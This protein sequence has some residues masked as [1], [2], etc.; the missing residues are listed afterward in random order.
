MLYDDGEI[1]EVDMLSGHELLMIAYDCYVVKLS[2]HAAW[3]AMEWVCCEALERAG[4]MKMWNGKPDSKMMII[5]FGTEEQAVVPRPDDGS[6]AGSEAGWA[7]PPAKKKGKKRDNRSAPSVAR[8]E[9][10]GANHA[11]I[12]T[13]LGTRGKKANELLA[14]LREADFEVAEYEKQRALWRR[15]RA[16]PADVMIHRTS[17]EAGGAV[18]VAAVAAA[19][20]VSYVAAAAAAADDGAADEPAR[21]AAKKAAA[22]APK[23]SASTKLGACAECNHRN[24]D[25]LTNAAQCGQCAKV[26]HLACWGGPELLKPPALTKRGPAW[27]CADCLECFGCGRS[28]RAVGPKCKITKTKVNELPKPQPLCRDCV[29]V[30]RHG[31]F[32]PKCCRAWDDDDQLVKCDGPG[33]RLWSHAACEGF[34]AADLAAM[35]DG[36]HEAF[37]RQ[38]LCS[39][40][41]AVKVGAKLV[42]KLAAIDE[43]KLFAEPVTEAVLGPGGHARYLE[44]VRH[45]MDLATMRSKA[46]RG[47]YRSAQ[48]V[49]ADCELMVL[50]ALKFNR[51]GDKYWKEACRFLDAAT[52]DV[53][54]DL[55]PPAP[56]PAKSVVSKD[57]LKARELRDVVKAKAKAEKEHKSTA[58]LKD[59]VA[60]TAVKKVVNIKRMPCGD[61]A[62]CLPVCELS[63]PTLELARASAWQDLCVVCGS[64]ETKDRLDSSPGEPPLPANGLALVKKAPKRGGELL[65]CVDCGEACHAMCAST[66][67]D[68]MSDAARATWRC[69]NCKVCELCGESKVDDESRL[70]YC[71]LCDKAYHLDCVTPKLDV[72]PPGRW[73]CGLCVT[74]RHCGKHKHA[75]GGWS[76]RLDCCLDCTVKPSAA[77]RK[78]HCAAGAA[79]FHAARDAISAR[80][81]LAFPSSQMKRCPYCAAYFHE[82]CAKVCLAPMDDAPPGLPQGCGRCRADSSQGG[83]PTHLGADETSWRV[84]L[85]AV[86]VQRRRFDAR[87]RARAPPSPSTALVAAPPRTRPLDGYDALDHWAGDAS[88]RDAFKKALNLGDWR[89]P[90]VCAV[91]RKAGDCPDSGRLVFVHDKQ[92]HWIHA[93]CAMWSSVCKPNLQPDFNVRVCVRFDARFSAVLRELDESN[94]FVQKSAKSTSI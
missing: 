80:V 15:D 84:A 85:A 23:P 57:G 92:H 94:R 36:S 72:A 41:C 26:Y 5:F 88:L 25:A 87:A 32:C 47:E 56:K 28:Q 90:R 38:F 52:A 30:Y 1:H 70:L 22:P 89:D 91:C 66:P 54:D 67:V 49:R 17:G 39:G 45:P 48:L 8:Y 58:V 63:L 31:K 59:R 16:L 7:A 62:S 78:G 6:E 44:V 74:C 77:P 18:D 3:P 64:G 27:L 13:V 14:A 9:V 21:P 20:Q 93:N 37:G 33:C 50:N 12:Q 81:S 82:A 19:P 60:G 83:V 40:G 79:C 65:F 69:P 73:I 4:T 35:A 86:A 24:C 51:D 55:D 11:G 71:D 76:S 43:W 75:A 68:S 42:A 34:D 29:G 61:P 53:F 2:G 46:E 10:G